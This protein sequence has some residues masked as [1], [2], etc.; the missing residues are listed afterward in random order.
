MTDR[1]PA[2]P[3]PPG[4]ERREVRPVPV[5]RTKSRLRDLGEWVAIILG[6]LVVA[7]LIKTFVVQTFYIPSLSM[8]PTLELN[9]RV[10][11]WKLDT[12][13]ERGDLFVFRNPRPDGE[14]RDLIKRVIATPGEVVEGRDGGVAVDGEMLVEDY[15]PDGTTT[16]SFGPVTIGPDEYWV[17]GDNRSS[18]SDSRDFGPIDGDQLVGRA[19]VRIWPLNRLSTL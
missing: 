4:W 15:L 10:L 8:V 6:A 7:F 3:T 11:A 5:N 12:S 13:P 1:P 19:L 17:M 18:S 9:D 2:Q 14:T 16:S